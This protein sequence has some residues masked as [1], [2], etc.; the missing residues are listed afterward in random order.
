MRNPV[1]YILF[2]IFI[3]CL[4]LYA[5]VGLVSCR[6][7]AFPAEVDSIICIVKNVHSGKQRVDSSGCSLP[8]TFFED[9]RNNI[10]SV[11]N[12]VDA[13]KL[14]RPEISGCSKGIKFRNSIEFFSNKKIVMKIS[15]SC[16]SFNGGLLDVRAEKYPYAVVFKQDF[17]RKINDAFLHVRIK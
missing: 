6:G 16:R 5:E 17:V 13:V 3:S 1:S 12:Y 4:D 8:L 10:D 11:I 9:F 2:I 14:K 7:P 15:F